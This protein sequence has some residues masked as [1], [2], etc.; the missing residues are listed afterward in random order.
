MSTLTIQLPDSLHGKLRELAD[1]KGDHI[2][3]PPN[4]A[5]AVVTTSSK[6]LKV[7]SVQ[8]PEFLEDDMI[9]MEEEEAPK[10]DDKGKKDSKD[11]KDKKDEIPEFE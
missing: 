3:V 9:F 10:K 6:P 1:A 2:I 7:I 5:H 8:S 4:T 11:K